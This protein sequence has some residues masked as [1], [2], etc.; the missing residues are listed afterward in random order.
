MI[1]NR[2]CKDYY[3]LKI[4]TIKNEIDSIKALG[5]DPIINILDEDLLDK[6]YKSYVNGI[7]KDCDILKI[8]MQILN[9]KEFYNSNNPFILNNNNH[10]KF[11]TK[12]NLDSNKNKAIAKGIY[13]YLINEYPFNLKQHKICIV[14]RSENVGKPIILKL[15]NNELDVRVITRNMTLEEKDKIIEESNI[16]ITCVNKP[17]FKAEKFSETQLV[18]DCGYSYINGKTIGNVF[19]VS[20]KNDNITP[21]KNG[22]N[23]L[24]RLGVMENLINYYC[25]LLT[26]IKI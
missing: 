8:K 4:K 22:V 2:N 11:N 7:S 13:D 19:D 12:K 16:I 15:I 26:K 3:N 10:Y 25:D 18:I 1:C 20:E 24:T 17:I 14:G 21:V 6:T 23:L 5:I 9:K